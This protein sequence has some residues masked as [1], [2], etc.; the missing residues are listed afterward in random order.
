MLTNSGLG[1]CMFA[2][3]KLRMTKKFGE[4]MLERVKPALAARFEMK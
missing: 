2:L 3:S 4:K 1:D